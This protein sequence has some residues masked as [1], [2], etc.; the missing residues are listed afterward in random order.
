WGGVRH[1]NPLY[2]A[3]DLERFAESNIPDPTDLDRAILHQIIQTATSMQKDA[4]LSDLVKALAPVLPSNNPERRTLIGILRYCGILRDPLKPSYF[5][6]FP[7]YSSRPH[8]P[9]HKDDW[10]YPVQWWN[11]SHRVS[12]DALSDWFPEPAKRKFELFG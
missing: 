11:G 8:T 6:G 1:S 5:E 4:K 2:M 9:W 3:F 7:H 12:L 10:P